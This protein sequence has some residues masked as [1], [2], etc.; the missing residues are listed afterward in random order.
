MNRFN[1]ILRRGATVLG[2]LLL[3][4]GMASAAI[5]TNINNRGSLLSFL[6]NAT[7]N[8]ANY[9]LTN[10]PGLSSISDQIPFKVFEQ[11]AD[12]ANVV[13]QILNQDAGDA[14]YH[15]VGYYQPA[16]VSPLTNGYALGPG[17]VFVVGDL[18]NNTGTA[19]TLINSNSISGQFG[20]FL[21]D[22]NQTVGPTIVGAYPS[23]EAF[24]PDQD[25]VHFAVFYDKDANGNIIDCSY[26]VAV[27]DLHN[28]GDLDYNDMFF[29][30]TG[31]GVIPEPGPIAGLGAMVLG[32]LAARRLRDRR[33]RKADVLTRK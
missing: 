4:H 1:S 5:V 29:R 16:G 26:L 32:L 20:L 18:D 12:S 11:C 30:I 25:D 2:A 8:A 7:G 6:T 15:K 23:E 27:E 14:A 9:S 19:L 17:I 22:R 24:D 33:N 28:G 3:M 13:F 10:A 31:A 21:Y